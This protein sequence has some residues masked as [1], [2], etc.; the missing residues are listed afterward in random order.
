MQKALPFS[1]TSEAGVSGGFHSAVT[2]M[3]LAWV[4][5]LFH[6]DSLIHTPVSHICLTTLIFLKVFL[7]IKYGSQPYKTQSFFYNTHLSY[8]IIIILF[9]LG[10]IVLNDK[11]I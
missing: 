8:N 6:V 3:S 9:N 1:K 10:N 4:L 5:F 7:L 11:S 2:C